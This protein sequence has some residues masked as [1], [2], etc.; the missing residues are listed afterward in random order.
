MNAAR[1]VVRA[2]VLPLAALAGLALTPPGPRLDPAHELVLAG[3]DTSM[4]FLANVTDPRLGTRWTLPVFDDRRWSEGR[5]GVGFDASGG[6]AALLST[7]VPRLAQSVYTRTVVTLD[8]LTGIGNVVVGADYDD[9]FA[10]WI[11]GTEVFRSP[12]MR[13][14]EPGWLQ[15]PQEHESSNGTSP[16]M[17]P[18][19]DVTARA[20]PALRLGRNV[21]AVAVWNASPLSD[22]L[23][24]VPFVSI[25]HPPDIVRGPY[26]QR[27]S[28]GAMVVRWRTNRPSDSR[29]WL[30]PA[31]GE[32]AAWAADAALTTEHEVELTG[33][34]PGTSY[35]YAVGDG[36]RMHAGNLHEEQS[37]TTPPPA[38]SSRPTRIWVLGDS[39]TANR[40]ARAVADAY[41]GIGTPQQTDLWLMLGDNAYPTGSDAQYQAAVFDMYPDFLRASV[42]WPTLGNHDGVTADSAS[43]T[44]PYYE[45][46]TLP[47]EAESGGVPS[48]TEAYYAFD[49]GNIH[50]I[51]LESHETDRSSLSAMLRWLEEDLAATS[52]DWIVAFWHHPPYSK[53]SHDSDDE[54]E[55]IQMRENALPILEAGGVD[56]VLTGHSHSYERSVLIDGHYGPSST[57]TSEMVLDAGL[58]R[59]EVTGAYGKP[60]GGPAP[61]EGAV[62]V[63]AG[64]S[65]QISPGELDHPVMIVSMMRLGSLVLD[66]DGGRLDAR[67]LAVP[68][69]VADRFTIVKHA[70]G[71]QGGMEP[72][73]P[74][75]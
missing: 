28:P 71:S 42:L 26:L 47:R 3:P 46:F 49:H 70:A 4:R 23:V 48:G 72:S 21:I 13:P 56:L 52:Q 64:S 6:A 65:G 10:V 12:E 63:V 51:C 74:P 61:H 1:A 57:L 24:L 31:S 73:S 45:I 30:G 58:G 34:S 55:L 33:L 9:A 53:G 69:Q 39:G 54:I 20:L 59:P 62:Y 19:T 7:R 38:G 43:Q 2:W 29:V 35:H 16:R 25:N 17:L 14:G 68:G 22:D 75:F 32:L 50:F 40:S 66:V 60:A 8:D 44:G 18:T 15:H 67:F 11:N 27:A 36:A 5:F 41:R 37:F